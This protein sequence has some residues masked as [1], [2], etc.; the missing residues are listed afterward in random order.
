MIQQSQSWVYT[1]KKCKAN[2]PSS[3]IYNSQDVET[4]QVPINRQL[5]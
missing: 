2:V 4:I 3:S 5:A 1:Q